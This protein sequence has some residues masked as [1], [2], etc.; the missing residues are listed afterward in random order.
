MLDNVLPTELGCYAKRMKKTEPMGEE[1]HAMPPVKTSLENERETHRHIFTRHL[2]H[3]VVKE[4]GNF[5]ERDSVPMNMGWPFVKDHK[6]R[7]LRRS[8]G[9]H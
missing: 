3:F 5:K 6:D 1:Y 9:M 4:R 7:R 8:A 2:V